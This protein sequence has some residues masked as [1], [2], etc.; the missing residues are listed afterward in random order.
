MPCRGGSYAIVAG[1]SGLAELLEE[2]RRLRDANAQVMRDNERLSGDLE[3]RTA[4]RDAAVRTAEE[5]A[6][7]L[8]LLRGERTGPRSQRV[9]DPTV[10]PLLPIFAREVAPP[11]A[12]EPEPEGDSDE[13]DSSAGTAR[14]RRR[15]RG[16]RRDRAAY[17]H[18]PSKTIR[19]PAD[20]D[21]ACP[22]CGGRLR[23]VGKARTFRV[24][25][26][27][28]H[29][30]VL[31]FERDKCTCDA[32]SD[33]GVLTVPAPCALD[34][35]LCGDSL[36]ARVLV[37]KFADHLPLHRQA[38]RM[39]REGFEVR[40][41][42][43]SSWVVQAAA[44]LRP[45]AEAVR[46]QVLDHPFIQGDDTRF[47]VQDGGDGALRKC[48]MWAFTDQLQ[49]YYAI[50]DT[51]AG[52]FP[53]ALL[54]GF[55]G[56]CLV[57]DAGS[58]FNA[59]VTE[60]NLQRAGCWS[61]LRT[62]FHRALDEHPD[63]AGTAIATFRSLFLL[64]RQWVDLSPE[65]RLENRRSK[66]AP[67]VDAFFE[68]VRNLSQTVRPRSLLGKAIAYALRQETALRLFLERGDIPMHNNLSELLLRQP[69]V[70]RKNWLFAGSEGGA[71]A[72]ATLF[73]LI[74][75][76]LL[77]GID[78]HAYLTDILPRIGNHPAKRVGELTPKAWADT[79]RHRQDNA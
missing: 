28:G 57:A 63:Q 3:Q 60:Q 52:V 5:L 35:A 26:V 65:E 4:E 51:K 75:S 64:E 22:S 30:E 56:N 38:K 71:Q 2:N 79:L 61:H 24:E 18:L 76:C 53:V 25:W 17:A 68:W 33:P 41:T 42:T 44:L 78:P 59:V 50:T 6:Q 39:G 14:T 46:T 11:A 12:P 55:K 67:L 20:P 9:V 48:R 1:M 32:C 19:C 45:V 10:E 31:D 37:D 7:T 8:A 43:L 40:T 70:G 58:E 69:V 36:L 54:D 34:K 66:A 29:F 27:P 15:K 49:A 23:I 16:V 62:Y 73:T 21:A 72:A 13:P 77:Q 47:P 74:G